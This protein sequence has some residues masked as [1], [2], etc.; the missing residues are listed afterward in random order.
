MKIAAATASGSVEVRHRDAWLLLALHHPWQEAE[1]VYF[2]VAMAL[3]QPD[4]R[5][6]VVDAPPRKILA[7]MEYLN[8]ELRAIV[9]E[10]NEAAGNKPYDS[11]GVPGRALIM[12][13][14]VN[15]GL[16]LDLQGATEELRRLGRHD[17]VERCGL[18]LTEAEA[19][20]ELRRMQD[21]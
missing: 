18:G 19:A 20:A 1:Q 4:P 6:T 2:V 14:A 13:A 15:C 17:I 5:G 7:A 21:G 11:I 8:R 9:R 3:L 10:V 12:H 16:K